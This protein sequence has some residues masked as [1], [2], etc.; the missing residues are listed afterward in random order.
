MPE[1]QAA[2]TIVVPWNDPD[3]VAAALA[4]H[5]VAAILAEPIAGEHGRR[6]A[7]GRASSRELRRLA[8]EHGALLVLD[9]VISGFRV[10]RGGA[11]EL[12]G[13]DADLTIMG[14]VLGG[15]LPAAAY[16]G[17]RELMSRVAPAGDVYQAGTLSGNPLAVAAGSRPC[18]QLDAA[19]LRPPRRA[20]A[21]ML[22]AGLRDAAAAAGVPLQVAFAPGLVTPFFSAEPGG[23]TSPGAAACDLDA[24]G[25][26]CRALLDRGIYPPRVAV[27]GMVRLPRPRRGGDRPHLRGGGRGVRGGGRD[28]RRRTAATRRPAHALSAA[29][30]LRAERSWSARTSPRRRRGAGARRCL[31]RP[32][33]GP[34]AP[35]EY[36]LVVEAVREGYLLHY[37]EPARGRRAAPTPTSRCSPATTSTRSGSSGSR[38]SATSRRCASSPT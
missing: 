36:A 38:R 5:E 3:A 2:A 29:A 27:R 11:Q 4:E 25:R 19:R 23:A 34:R 33:R 30:P 1:A 26:F 31:P 6:P 13:V 32:A 18:V 9:E 28:E 21:R 7:R 22:A 15:G 8:D 16:G 24:Y 17:R 10:A 20:H 37:A 14:K 35:R 12:Y